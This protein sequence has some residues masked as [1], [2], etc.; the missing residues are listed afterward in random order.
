ML[1]RP[2]FYLR[3]RFSRAERAQHIRGIHALGAAAGEQ[4][5]DIAVE[6]L[7]KAYK[8][9]CRLIKVDIQRL[10]GTGHDNIGLFDTDAE[11]IAHIFDRR[12]V[13]LDKAA[14][15][16][17]GNFHLVIENA[18]YAEVN[19]EQLGCF[20]HIVAHGVSVDLANGRVGVKYPLRAVVN[21]YGLLARYA[22]Q[23]GLASAGEACKLMRLDLAYL[24]M[25]V[26]LIST[27]V[28]RYGRSVRAVAEV[29]EII[30]VKRRVVY[31]FDLAVKLAESA[32]HLVLGCRAVNADGDEERDVFKLDAAINKLIDRD[33]GHGCRGN[34]ARC[35]RY[36][37]A[38]SF[39]ALVAHNLMQS[40]A[41]NRLGKRLFDRRA[42]V[43]CRKL[44][45]LHHSGAVGFRQAQLD[46]QHRVFI[47][48]H[49]VFIF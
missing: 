36:Q 43:N 3:Q 34:A 41:G 46:A 12:A 31:A 37:D 45:C 27:A 20:D 15:E 38:G 1:R 10:T 16:N 26:T 17:G 6:Y 21:A 22:G 35:I 25:N 49:A 40:F 14:G 8:R 2:L 23:D 13:A 24:N 44:P 42:L 33:P 32:P 7:R 9:L 4:R 30:L 28:Y 39:R 11:I 29:D 18:V 5:H 48:A 19:A 47:Y